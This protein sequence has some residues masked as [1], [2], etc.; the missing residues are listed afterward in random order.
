MRSRWPHSQ[1][2]APAP[3]PEP[4]TPPDPVTATGP[5]PGPGPAPNQEAPHVAHLSNDGLLLLTQV[6]LTAVLKL[7]VKVLVYFQNLKRKGSGGGQQRAATKETREVEQG[8]SGGL[9][10]RATKGQNSL[11]PSAWDMQSLPAPTVTECPCT[12]WVRTVVYIQRKPGEPGLSSRHQSH[13]TCMLVPRGRRLA[14][15][16]SSSLTPNLV[17]SLA[18]GKEHLPSYAGSLSSDTSG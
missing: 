9:A 12:G 13:E 16:F 2:P 14:W 5:G 17:L 7:P 3:N 4:A 1:G 18:L 11:Y 10:S 8:A 15:A 6:L